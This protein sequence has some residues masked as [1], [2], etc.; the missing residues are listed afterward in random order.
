ML[1]PECDCTIKFAHFGI[2]VSRGQQARRK[3]TI[4][5]NAID[6]NH[7]EKAELLFTQWA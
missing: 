3:I 5:V 6:L 4:L 7:P 1:Q 2:L